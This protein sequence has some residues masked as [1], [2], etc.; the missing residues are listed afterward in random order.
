MALIRVVV[1]GSRVARR[2]VLFVAGLAAMVQ[3]GPLAAMSLSVAISLVAY[4]AAFGFPFALGF[5]I[6]LLIHEAGHM[7]AAR[8]SGI[9][10][11]WPVLIPF[12]GAVIN[13]RKAPVNANMEANIALGGPA[14]GTLSALSC[15]A[16]YFWTDNLV[17]L[18]LSY[19]ACLLN[20]FNLIP[21]SPMDGGRIAA[22]I[23][24]RLWWAGILVLGILCYVTRNF[25]ILTVFLFSLVHMWQDS[26]EEYSKSYFQLTVRQRLTI[27]WWYF[28]L[29]TVLSVLTVSLVEL[30]R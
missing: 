29:L 18:I 8:V 14:L 22:A 17:L 20:L 4:A 5:V 13:L 7:L 16:L 28:C 24:P 26:Q 25:L 19:T 12:L 6:L 10:V 11:S 1:C 30:L 9:T 3:V 2:A 23:S 21:C 27:A 15:L